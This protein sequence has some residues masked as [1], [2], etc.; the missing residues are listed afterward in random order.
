MTTTE[1]ARIP[2]EKEC[3]PQNG[4]V[5][6]VSDGKK[7]SHHLLK[8]TSDVKWAIEAGYSIDVIGLSLDRIKADQEARDRKLKFM[9]WSEMVEKVKKGSGYILLSDLDKALVKA[10]KEVD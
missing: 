10:F 4:D 6:E 5:V 8:R 3:V 2:G 9:I 1:K 7:F